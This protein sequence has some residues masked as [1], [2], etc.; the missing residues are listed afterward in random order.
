M[1]SLVVD[2]VY[3]Q[4]IKGLAYI[5]SFATRKAAGRLERSEKIHAANGSEQVMSVSFKHCHVRP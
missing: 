4:P 2:I 1:N 3:V 5:S